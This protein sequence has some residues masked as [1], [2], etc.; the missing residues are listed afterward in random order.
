M[1]IFAEFFGP[2]RVGDYEFR[3]TIYKCTSGTIGM[4]M[5]SVESNEIMSTF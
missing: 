2:S 3:K 1:W 4:Y 5:G